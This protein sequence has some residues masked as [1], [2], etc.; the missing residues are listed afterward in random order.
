VNADVKYLVYKSIT[1]ICADAKISLIENDKPVSEVLDITARGRVQRSERIASGGY[2]LRCVQLLST[3]KTL[4]RRV[5]VTSHYG[6][7]EPK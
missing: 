1:D 6:H 4:A 7:D 5:T 3:R 2:R